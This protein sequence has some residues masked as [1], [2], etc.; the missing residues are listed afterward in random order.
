MVRCVRKLPVRFIGSTSKKN[1]TL[2]QAPLVA[3]TI[4]SPGALKSARRLKK[5][6]VDFL[7]ARVD[8]FASDPAAF[9][10]I[11]RTLEAPL[12]ITVRDVAEGGAVA[13]SKARRK[14][15]FSAFMNVAAFIDVELRGAA[16]FASTIAEAREGGV[17]VII[18]DHHFRAMPTATRLRE[19]LQ[20]ALSFGPDIVKVAA[21]ASSAQDLLTLL[22]AM[23][24]V[25]EGVQASFMGMGT[26]GKV[27]RLVFA[28]AGSV[29]NYGYL[30]KPQVPG[31]WQ[32]QILKARLAELRDLS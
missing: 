17:G 22:T 3:G 2:S 29:I 13:L 5:G 30:D 20:R 26:F 27:S 11:C 14:E 23:T 31:Q 8:H 12:I 25:P 16:S 1:R 6:D 21:T 19:R 15:L 18:S 4:H 9:H 32:A 10:A 24:L 28:A 7:E